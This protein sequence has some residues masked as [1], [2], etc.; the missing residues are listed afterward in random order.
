MDLVQSTLQMLRSG[1]PME[2]PGLRTNLLNLLTLMN[3]WDD[4]KKGKVPLENTFYLVGVPDPTGTLE[5]NEVV[6]LRSDGALY[7]SVLVYRAPGKHPGDLHMVQAVKSQ[8]LEDIVGG[9]KNVIFFSVQGTRPLVHEIANGDF[10]G[11][12]YWICHNQKV[13]SSQLNLMFERFVSF[14]LELV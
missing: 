2:E 5:K 10:D 6:I 11:D 1:I 14:V 12:L 8:A 3:K 4:L 9:G 13:H 7:G